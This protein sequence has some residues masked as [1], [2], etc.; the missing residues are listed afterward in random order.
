[1]GE[2]SKVKNYDILF[3]RFFTNFLEK[4]S[5]ENQ[6][7]K[8]SIFQPHNPAI[9]PVP[10]AVFKMNEDVQRMVDVYDGRR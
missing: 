4:E 6:D 1:M 7:R 8:Y 5:L 10:E 2:T 9:T 3:M